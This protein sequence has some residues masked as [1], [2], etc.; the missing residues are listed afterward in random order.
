[1]T[2]KEAA[3]ALGV[4]NAI[5]YAA[6]TG[7]VAIRWE[8]AR[9]PKVWTVPAAKIDPADARCELARRYLHIF[10]PATADGFAR[11]AGAVRE[12]EGRMEWRGHE[13]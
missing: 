1:M 7:T 13:T 11:W 3:D 5:R 4:R 9:A 2:D 12:R 8:G 6:T 10:G